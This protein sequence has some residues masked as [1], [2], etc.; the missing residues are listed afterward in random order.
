MEY[1]SP[2]FLLCALFLLTSL[3]C[4][5]AYPLL[6]LNPL[7]SIVFFIIGVLAVIVLLDVIKTA[8]LP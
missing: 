1:F 8:L 5:L 6:L 3:L 7:F 2:F 4:W